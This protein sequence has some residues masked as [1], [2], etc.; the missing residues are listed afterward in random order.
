MSAADQL[1]TRPPPD[2]FCDLVMQGGVTNGVLYPTAVVALSRYYRFQS[3]GGT[4]IGAAA[5]ALTA[6][7]EYARRHGDDE[8][9]ERLGRLLSAAFRGDGESPPL[10]DRF[11]PAPKTERLFKVFIGSLE[12]GSK[13]GVLYG[14]I[15][16]AIKTYWCPQA[17]GIAAALAVLYVVHLRFP[18]QPGWLVWTGVVLVALTAALIS[19]AFAAFG[20]L[21]KLV[22]N[23]YGLCSLGPGVARGGAG[24]AFVPWLH[25]TI[26]EAARP[27]AG[28]PLTFEDLWRAP[29]FDPKQFGRTNGPDARSIDLQVLSTCL[30]RGRPYRF[31]RTD[32]EEKDSPLYFDPSDL[33]D[34]FPTDVLEFMEEHS[35]KDETSGLYRL[36]NGKLPIVV[37]ARLSLSFPLLISAVPL[38][39]IDERPGAKSPGPQRCW[40][41]DG[42][43][44]SNFPI[45]LFD[46]FVPTWPTFGIA[47]ESK[48]SNPGVGDA[49]LQTIDGQRA[50][51]SWN[52]FDAPRDGSS[53]KRIEQLANF[54][55]T[56]IST[57]MDR[58]DSTLMRMPGVRDRVVR[59][60]LDPGEGGVNLRISGDEI[61]ELAEKYGVPAATQFVER[62]AIADAPDGTSQGW[63]E[64][65]WVRLNTLLTALE[66]EF[67]CSALAAAADSRSHSRPLATQIN[68]AFMKPPV[69]GSARLSA[70]QVADIAV[71]LV[72]LKRLEDA[73]R[74]AGQASPGQSAYRAVPEPTVRVRPWV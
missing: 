13:M 8:S 4:S 35:E 46:A 2:R 41:S 33:K 49:Y 54:V 10:L 3:I 23:G 68:E 12:R 48:D 65:R 42:G 64:H 69:A 32:V 20:D 57:L 66:K 34:Y 73:W 1:G 22:D 11:Q 27:R 21:R 74:G 67:G 61:A 58:D 63:R 14:A 17:L 53:D 51:D 40:F 45:H 56:I 71:K 55:W 72:A 24:P 47:L 36:P 9:F 29:G 30:T 6:A 50:P 60:F 70:E 7:A 31:P 19:L 62:F 28:K 18:A 5:A 37:A 26:Q 43:I 44:C 59:L 52:P 38:R 25:Q 16:S 15:W 39:A